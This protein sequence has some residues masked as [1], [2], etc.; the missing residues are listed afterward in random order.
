M[1]TEK[2]TRSDVIAGYLPWFPRGC[3]G[4]RRAADAQAS[5]GIG[6][7]PVF[8]PYFGNRARKV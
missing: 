5:P 6:T 1:T 8:N 4:L 7:T 2:R 3:L